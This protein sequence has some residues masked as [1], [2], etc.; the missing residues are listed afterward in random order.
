[1]PDASTVE[2]M[3][4]FYDGL[5]RD[6]LEPEFALAQAQARLAADR[7]RAFHWAGFVLTRSTP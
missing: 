6:R 3:S 2:L 1:M 5:L 4:A 7:W